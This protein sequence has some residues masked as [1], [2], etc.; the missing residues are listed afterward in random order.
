LAAGMGWKM[1]NPVKA[2][3]AGRPLWVFFPLTLL[4]SWYPWLLS[5]V[6][7]KAS[8]I[9]PLGVLVAAL[10]V[11]GASGGWPG[12][13]VVLLRVIRVR[14]GGRWYL[15]ALL[16][17]VVF[18]F[19]AL[20]VNLAAGAPA[21]APEAWAKSS[22]IIDRFVFGFLFVGLGEEPGWRGYALPEL[23]RRRSALRAALILGAFWAL[24][25]LP[26]FGT[27][28]S[29]NL[30]PAFVMSVFAGSV[31]AAWL[32]NSSGQSVFIT[33]LMHAEVNAIGAGYVFRFFTGADYL[34][35]WWIYTLVWVA[36]ALLVAWR[37]GPGLTGLRRS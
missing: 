23:M 16:L 13:K 33:M 2:L 8:G 6:G 1:A 19:L 15:M 5:F 28:F 20:A 31:I 9:N 17:P 27:E 18:V 29:W 32:F 25:H 36:G 10:I 7:V 3:F 35:L 21:P 37:A 24:W 11:A 4:L 22:E 26:L 14:F 12:L 34:R 30:L